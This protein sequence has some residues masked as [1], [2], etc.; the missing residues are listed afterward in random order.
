MA[1]PARRLQTRRRHPTE[2]GRSASTRP[3]HTVDTRPA[4]LWPRLSSPPSPTPSMWR[5]RGRR[6]LLPMRPSTPIVAGTAERAPRRAVASYVLGPFL[7]LLGFSCLGG[8][9][10]KKDKQRTFSP[11]L[12]LG[13][14]RF[15]SGRHASRLGS[16]RPSFLP[17]PRNGHCD[18]LAFFPL[19]RAC[20]GTRAKKEKEAVAC[21]L[22]RRL[23]RVARPDRRQREAKKNILKKYPVI[24]H[25]ILRATKEKAFF[26]FGAWHTHAATTHTTGEQQKKREKKEGPAKA[27]S[28]WFLSA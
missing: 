20:S 18:L 24:R 2:R 25:A 7:Y 27:Q 19:P 22:R 21:P 17:C 12:C 6:W 16:G 1:P 15:P 8:N 5:R 28:D 10:K 3:R 14:S 23:A 11:S 13:G 4:R 9:R 26:L